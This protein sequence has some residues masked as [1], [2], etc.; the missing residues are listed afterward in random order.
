MQLHIQAV[1]Q[2]NHLVVVEWIDLLRLERRASMEIRMKVRHMLEWCIQ[3]L[4]LKGTH[5]V[6]LW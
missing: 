6:D 4:Y 2:E 5:V 3:V 1:N